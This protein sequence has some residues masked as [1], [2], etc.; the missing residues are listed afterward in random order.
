MS[1]RFLGAGAL[2]LALLAVGPARSDYVNFESSHVHPIALTPSGGRLLAVNTPDALL[3]V[4]SV[5]ADGRL[6]PRPP[7]PVGLEPV[8]V[9]AR[10]DSEAWVVNHLSDTVSIVD[11]DQ[12]TT[13]R[14]LPVGDEPTDVVFAKGRA[15]VAV[16]QEDA[17][18]VFNLSDLAAAPAKLDLFGR[19]TRALAV[20]K[21]GNK[22]YAVVLNS[23]NQTTIVN[24]NVI[25]GNSARLDTARL[26][27]LGL[28]NLAC[29]GP[30]PPYPPLPPGIQRNQA[31]NDPSPPA[32]PQV[33]LIVKWDASTAAWRD[34]AGQDWGAAAR[35]DAG[36]QSEAVDAE[37]TGRGGAAGGAG[38]SKFSAEQREDPEGEEEDTADQVDGGVV[39]DED[40]P[41]G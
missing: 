25:A 12:G 22:V 17:V 33:S 18:K 4:F 20:S 19:N 40:P 31:L 38:E 37:R 34:D 11:L 6:T 23:G 13:V 3:E 26:G 30:P 32:Q 1:A 41:D 28:N 15:F 16:S 8:T 29:L 14:T 10:T 7:I 21:D 9:V 2:G 24:A 27:Q 35:R 5:G 36:E 39:V